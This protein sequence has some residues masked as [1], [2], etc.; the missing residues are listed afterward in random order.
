[1]AVVNA[2]QNL[3]FAHVVRGARPLWAFVKGQTVHTLLLGLALNVH[4]AGVM[5]F[6][7]VKITRCKAQ[8]GV[9]KACTG[10]LHRKVELEPRVWLPLAAGQLIEDTYYDASS[11]DD[12]LA[13]YQRGALD[14]V[15]D[16]RQEADDD[17]DITMNTAEDQDRT[18]MTTPPPLRAMGIEA[19]VR[20][21]E[22]AADW[23][24]AAH[25]T[26]PRGGARV[27]LGNIKAGNGYV[28]VVGQSQLHVLD[29]TIYEQL[30]LQLRVD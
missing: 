2:A 24:R 7:P 8:P 3:I 1:M 10:D 12:L 9:S 6:S 20:E 30:N 11:T 23:A 13:A 4:V 5:P 18:Q 29:P 14:A 25:A 26:Y 21:E 16:A 17:D 28:H 22:E 27:V 15:E 19:V